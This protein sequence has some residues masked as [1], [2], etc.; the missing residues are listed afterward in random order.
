MWQEQLPNV[1]TQNKVYVAAL[2]TTVNYATHS[3]K[4]NKFALAS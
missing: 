3:H 1:T 4:R 2:T